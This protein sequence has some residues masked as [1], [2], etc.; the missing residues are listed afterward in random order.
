MVRDAGGE[1]VAAEAAYDLDGALL[2]P[3]QIERPRRDLEAASVEV[4]LALVAQSTGSVREWALTEATWSAAWRLQLGGDRRDVAGS[5]RARPGLTARPAAGRVPRHRESGPRPQPL[6]KSRDLSQRP[7]TRTAHG[8]G[9]HHP[10]SPNLWGWWS[11]MHNHAFDPP[12]CESRIRL[13][14]SC[15]ARSCRSAT[16]RTSRLSLRRRRA[17]DDVRDLGERRDRGVRLALGVA[18]LVG[19]DRRCAGRGSPACP[20]LW[21][22]QTSSKSRSPT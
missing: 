12:R 10:V 17:G 22:P 16:L 11:D 7:R 19:R 6:G 8:V 20:A 14:C 2:R 13:A 18:D 1:P 4:L 9:Q 3:P 15:N 21:A 5:S